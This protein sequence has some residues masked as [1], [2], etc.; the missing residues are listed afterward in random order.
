MKK[1]WYGNK[2]SIWLCFAWHGKK[3]AN[4]NDQNSA[5]AMHFI[6]ETVNSVN[7]YA[8]KWNEIKSD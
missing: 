3:G 7:T 1:V 2:Q 8:G 4:Y 6:T 5:I